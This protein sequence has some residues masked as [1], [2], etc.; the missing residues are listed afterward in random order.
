MV[1]WDAM[2]SYV[3]PSATG[4]PWKTQAHPKSMGRSSMIKENIDFVFGAMRKMSESLQ[5]SQKPTDHHNKPLWQQNLQSAQLPRPSGHHSQAS[6]V[7]KHWPVEKGRQGNSK[8][9]TSDP[10]QNLSIRPWIL[11]N[12]IWGVTPALNQPPCQ[13]QKSFNI[14][15]QKNWK[16]FDSGS[17]S[18]YSGVILLTLWPRFT[19]QD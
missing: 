5:G 12:E 19:F 3:T 6:W 17:I 18:S 10:L 13:T 11:Q 8:S 9:K 4:S 14:L 2:R 7:A 1:I 16:G 15:Q